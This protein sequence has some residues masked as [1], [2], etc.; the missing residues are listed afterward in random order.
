[1]RARAKSLLLKGRRAGAWQLFGCADFSLPQATLG[2]RRGV[3]STTAVA[4]AAQVANRAGPVRP[5]IS[6]DSDAVP[7]LGLNWFRRGR[8]APRTLA[9]KRPWWSKALIR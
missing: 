8:G 7:A 1:M 4:T 9:E 3:A 5:A 2:E 6:A